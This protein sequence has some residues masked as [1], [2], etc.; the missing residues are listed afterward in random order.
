MTTVA[1]RYDP[2]TALGAIPTPNMG[3]YIKGL[4]K[5][6]GMLLGY[7]DWAI[8][9][10]CGYSLINEIVE[11]FAGDWA[12]LEIASGGWER[13]GVS[14][15][16]TGKNIQACAED[17]QRSWEGEA[18]LVARQHLIALAEAHRKQGEGCAIIANQCKGIVELAKAAGDVLSVVLSVVNNIAMKIAAQLMVPVIGWITGAATAPW[19]A[20]SIYENVQKVV[21]AVQAVV[22]FMGLAARI[23]STVQALVAVANKV[24]TT[25]TRSYNYTNAQLMDE[26]AQATSG[27]A[28]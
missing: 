8:Q 2:I 15:T 22:R 24:I 5:N 4:R 14:L 1:E 13:I 18:E 6:A 27:V 20:K 9:K 25:A 10:V 12:V 28:K 17:L 11:P 19:M 3:E 26:T 7:T 23:I 21:K 16:A